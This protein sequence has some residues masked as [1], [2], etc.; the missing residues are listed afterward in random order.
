M[1]DQEIV[2]RLKDGLRFVITAP[3]DWRFRIKEVEGDLKL[4]MERLK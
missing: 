3:G 2:G 4:V 1:T